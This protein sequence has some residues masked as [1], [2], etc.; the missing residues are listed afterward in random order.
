MT[1]TVKILI[2]STFLRAG[3]TFPL[4]LGL[5]LSDDP[6]GGHVRVWLG[7]RAFTSTRLGIRYQ[8]INMAQTFTES[9]F[10]HDIA[11]LNNGDDKKPSNINLL[12]TKMFASSIEIADYLL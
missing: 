9:P 11:F 8:S 5:T 7:L 10:S 2:Y 12:I 6:Q 4:G 1:K 3:Q